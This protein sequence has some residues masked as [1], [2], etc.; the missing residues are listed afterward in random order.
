[1]SDLFSDRAFPMVVGVE[2][3][4]SADP[5][6]KGNWTS[7]VIGKGVLLGTKFGISAASYPTLD[8]P[9]LTLGEAKAIYQ[10]QFWNK[11]FCDNLPPSLAILAFDTA[12]NQG[13]H[14]SV[15]L[16]QMAARVTIDGI[17]GPITLH[18]LQTGNERD[19]FAIMT[20]SRAMF[21][22]R[23]FDFPLYGH[24]WMNRLAFIVYDAL[25]DSTSN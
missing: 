18:A 16:L 12:V 15:M 25:V 17:L 19:Q 5:Q 3:G 4:F 13:P 1:M 20:A 21:Y 23:D 14:V 2:G 24:G 11:L 10:F 22:T 6:D 7:G 8:I 9:N